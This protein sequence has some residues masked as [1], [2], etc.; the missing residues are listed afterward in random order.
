MA[1]TPRNVVPFNTER[2]SKNPS[3]QQIRNAADGPFTLLRAVWPEMTAEQQQS[4]SSLAA[5]LVEANHAREARI[6][7]QGGSDGQ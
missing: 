1:R 2:R 6:E 4:I 3:I 7:A 5:D